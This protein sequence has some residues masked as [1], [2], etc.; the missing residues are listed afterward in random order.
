MKGLENNHDERTSLFKK[1]GPGIAREMS[2][3][4]QIL[5]KENIQV[6]FT[7]IQSFEQSALVVDVGE[8]CFGSYVNF[9][10]HKDGLEGITM[11][12]FPLSSTKSLTE[13]MIKLY[14]KK[15]DEKLGDHELKLSAFKEG[16]H[17]LLMSH[18][19]GL[20][21][22]LKVKLNMSVP[23]F[24]C[25]HNM[26][27]MKSAL[28]RS[29]SRLDSMVSIGQ[30]RIIKCE[31]RDNRKRDIRNCSNSEIKGRFIIVF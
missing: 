25:F 19:T 12:A 26:K 31:S 30:F 4:L 14:F 7:G 27:F 18:T 8:K 16:T 24:V 23:K 17:I 2:K 13:F 9:S 15:D 21:N 1:I 20:A 29:R 11:A 10:S 3:S 22:A 5:S 28:L 6:E